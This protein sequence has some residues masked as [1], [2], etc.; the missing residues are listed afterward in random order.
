MCTELYNQWRDTNKSMGHNV[1]QLKFSLKQHENRLENTD[2]EIKE[3]EKE[4]N[5]LKTAIQAKGAPLKLAQTRLNMRTQRGM[6][7][8]GTWEETDVSQ[9]ALVGEVTTILDNLNLLNSQLRQEEKVYKDLLINK[10]KMEYDIRV[11]N[12]S[13]E[14][15]VNKCLGARKVLP[16]TLRKGWE[17]YL[18]KLKESAKQGDDS[19]KTVR[20]RRNSQHSQASQ[21][22]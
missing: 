8:R 6:K 1:Q 17:K 16:M 13:L 22:G 20:R 2:R 14:I 7:G 21:E 10:Q 4:T 3:Q 15:E 19:Q 11:K 12:H 18:E 9:A 5:K